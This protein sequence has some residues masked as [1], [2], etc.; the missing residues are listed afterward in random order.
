M[1]FFPLISII[2]I[3][4]YIYLYM[5]MAIIEIVK[6]LERGHHGRNDCDRR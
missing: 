1:T 6:H 5:R 2:A 3:L 4:M